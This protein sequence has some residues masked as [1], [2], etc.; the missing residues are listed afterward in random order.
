M[1]ASRP[2]TSALARRVVGVVVVG[3]GDQL[4]QAGRAAGEQEDRDVAG[5]RPVRVHGGRAAPA[6]PGSAHSGAQ[7]DV[8]R[9]R[10]RRRPRGRAAA[11]LRHRRPARAASAWWSKPR[12]AVG[13]GDRGGLGVRGQVGQLGAAV[14][15]QRH[16]RDDPGAQAGQGQDDELPAVGQ[17]HDDPVAR[18][19]A[20]VAAA[21]P[22]RRRRGRRARGRSAAA[23]PSTSATA[24]GVRSAASREQRRRAGGPPSS[25]RAT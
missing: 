20:E 25:P 7:V 21:G 4:R 22:R 2:H 24:S 9:A 15:G 23:S 10:R 17:L 8:R 18:L 13:H 5:C 14:R 3:A 12:S 19:E 1:S 16:D 6:S 11:V